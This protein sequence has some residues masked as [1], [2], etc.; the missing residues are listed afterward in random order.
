MFS[1]SVYGGV[2]DETFDDIFDRKE[3]VVLRCEGFSYLRYYS[4]NLKDKVIKEYKKERSWD[5][6][7]YQIYKID[8][9]YINGSL[10]KE[11]KFITITR[12]QYEKHIHIRNV[13]KDKNNKDKLVTYKCLVGEK[14]F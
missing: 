14:V 5:F 8:E 4:V 13:W 7:T 11:E 1:G 6:Q 12:H 10:K 2:I 9:V 3:V